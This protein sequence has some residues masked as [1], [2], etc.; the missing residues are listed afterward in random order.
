MSS[1][2]GGLPPLDFL[3]HSFSISVNVMKP[4]YPHQA[5]SFPRSG[6]GQSGF[7][8]EWFLA[9]TAEQHDSANG[10]AGVPLPLVLQ[11]AFH[12]APNGMVICNSGAIITRV[13]AVAERL[14]QFDPI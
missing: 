3:I 9:E 11:S 7:R 8:A 14:A 13:N 6:A 10:F 4:K 2:V 5:A 1:S 12:R